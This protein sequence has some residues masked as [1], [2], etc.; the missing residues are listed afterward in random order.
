MQNVL[1]A[2][3]TKL[4][5][6][7]PIWMFFLILRSAVINTTTFCALKLDGFT[8]Y[9]LN[10]VELKFWMSGFIVREEF[11]FLRRGMKPPTG[12]EPVTSSLPRTCSTD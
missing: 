2:E 3:R 1:T 7:D 12:I 8:H 10:V 11:A 9:Y 4:F 6:L 5:N